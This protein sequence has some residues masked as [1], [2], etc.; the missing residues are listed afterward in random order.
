MK[1]KN[2]QGVFKP[3]IMEQLKLPM[4][5]GELIPENNLVRME[6]WQLNAYS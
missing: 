3:N 4:D 2:Q 6:N 5:L 1:K